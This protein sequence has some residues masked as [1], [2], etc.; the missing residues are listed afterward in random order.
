MIVVDFV[1]SCFL[2]DLLPA[3][4]GLGVLLWAARHDLAL[5]LLTVFFTLFLWWLGGFDVWSLVCRD[6]L[7]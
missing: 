5:W 6:V 7:S 4:L 2:T 1:G 3:A